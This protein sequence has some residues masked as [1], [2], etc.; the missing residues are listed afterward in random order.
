MEDNRE[1]HEGG[2]LIEIRDL[3][4]K[5]NGTE[6]LRDV[7]LTLKDGEFAGILGPNGAGKSTLLKIII[8]IID[9]YSGTIEIDGMPHK[10]WLSRNVIGYLPQYEDIDRDFPISVTDIVL[11]GMYY[12]KRRFLGYRR[13]DIKV[14]EEAMKMVG[15]FEKRK[16]L[17]GTLS[18]GEFQRMLIARA[19]SSGTNYLFL[20]EPEAGIDKKMISEFYSMLLQ[21]NS[22]GKTILIVSHDIGAVTRECAYIICLN[23]KLHCHTPKDLIDA[24]VIKETYGDVM[25]IIDKDY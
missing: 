9:D 20:D 7:N 1:A 11:M 21:L 8:G 3:N 16:R 15:I 13:S 17:A 4:Y 22:T 2:Q 12:K 24:K 25:R 6:I 5:K 18:G 10:E 19:L 23:K 14:A